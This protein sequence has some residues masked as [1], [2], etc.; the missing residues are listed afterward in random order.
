MVTNLLYSLKVW[1]TSVM[2]APVFHLVIMGIKHSDG[3]EQ[4]GEICRTYIMLTIFELL[5]SFVTW[6]IFFII[7]ILIGSYAK[8]EIAARAI[9]CAIGV[10]MVPAT[11]MLTLPDYR[12]TII[13]DFIYLIGGNCLC[14]AACSW[15]YKLKL[16]RHPEPV[17]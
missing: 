5:F 11:F 7:T 6:F 4:A 17:E 3:T 14:I 2:I 8:N 10:I 15:I 1:L 16:Y 9:I 13:G 12:L